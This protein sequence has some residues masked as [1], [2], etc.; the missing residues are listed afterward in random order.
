MVKNEGYK[1]STYPY[2]K[3]DSHFHECL[4]LGQKV[5]VK[6]LNWAW[7]VI[8]MSKGKQT[9]QFHERWMH[10]LKIPAVLSC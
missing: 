6:E 8:P 9:L 7:Q 1:Q 3:S 4:A 10:V 5:F 2:N